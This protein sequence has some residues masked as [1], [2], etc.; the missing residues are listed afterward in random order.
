MRLSASWRAILLLSTP[1]AIALAG[2]AATFFI[3]TRPIDVSRLQ[4]IP[5]RFPVLL[6][7]EVPDGPVNCR[8]QYFGTLERGAAAPPGFSFVVPADLVER[9]L[10]DLCKTESRVNSAGGRLW[11]VEANLGRVSEGGQQSVDVLAM[12]GDR[13]SRGWYVASQSGIEPKRYQGYFGPTAA[14][15]AVA[16]ALVSGILNA[17]AIV[18]KVRRDRRHGK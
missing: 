18:L 2:A 12:E 15:T 14:L 9:C 13:V 4:E 16:V 17:I 5:P 3:W 1:I 6:M 10:H 7:H 11:H 8:V